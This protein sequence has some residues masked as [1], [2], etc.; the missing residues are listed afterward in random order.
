M[1]KLEELPSRFFVAG[2]HPTGPTLG[3]N[4]VPNHESFSDGEVE[5]ILAED[6]GKRLDLHAPM[7]D[8][9]I[10][11]TAAEMES[12]R[13][14]QLQAILDGNPELVLRLHKLRA[15]KR[16]KSAPAVEAARRA[17]ANLYPSAMPDPATVRSKALYRAVLPNIPFHVS[18][19]TV[20]R[21]AG[22]RK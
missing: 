21:A 20:M 15:G 19:E 6:D 8:A 22:R 4:Y 5:K 17:L 9:W 7:S 2:D 13:Q 11:K 10:D 12:F 3:D 14:A 16:Q 18:Y 1:S